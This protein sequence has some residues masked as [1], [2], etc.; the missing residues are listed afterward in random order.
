MKGMVCASAVQVEE[1]MKSGILSGS[2]YAVFPT[3]GL[4]DPYGCYT[5]RPF[6]EIEGSRERDIEE[7]HV[8]VGGPYESGDAFFRDCVAQ[9]A[10]LRELRSSKCY[11]R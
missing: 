4:K 10:K 6:V 1:F 11:L 2:V 8:V 7:N 9:T 5:V 3:E